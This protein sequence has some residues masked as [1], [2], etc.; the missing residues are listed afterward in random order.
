MESGRRMEKVSED[1]GGR[2]YG[3][4]RGDAGR[5]WW[6]PHLQVCDEDGYGRDV[7]AHG[8]LELAH[9]HNVHAQADDKA[10]AEEGDR[11]DRLGNVLRRAV[12][13]L[14]EL[15]GIDE[16]V[17]TKGATRDGG[18]AG[19]CELRV[20]AC[21]D[22]LLDGRVLAPLPLLPLKLVIR[23]TELSQLLGDLTK[24]RRQ[25]AH[26]PAPLHVE[27]AQGDHRVVRRMQR[28]AG[29]AEAMIVGEV[30]VSEVG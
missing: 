15:G 2:R 3:E 12:C 6:S 19:A 29:L 30:K 7:L 20:G 14:V 18:Q 25:R 28:R 26:Q 24:P 13:T 17:V 1:R 16:P 9:Q 23:E 5:Y 10:D 22:E 27:P 11:E 21:R 4:I 8:R